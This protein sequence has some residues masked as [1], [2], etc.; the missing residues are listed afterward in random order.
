MTGPLIKLLI[1]PVDFDCN[2]ACGYCYNGTA[3]QSRTKPDYIISMGTIHKIFDGIVPL[4]KSDRLVV[5]WH[6]GE[7]TLPGQ[8]FYREAIRVQQQAIDSRYKVT[9]CMQTNGTLIDESWADLLAELKI[10][11]SVSIDG[12]RQLHDSIRKFFS[13]EESTY[14]L[15][16]RAYRLFQSRGINAGMLMVISQI[17]V[18]HPEAIWEWVL[19]ER[20]KHFDFLPCI[21]PELW[22][23]GKQVYGLST[24]DMA[25]F[26]IKFFDLWFDH[27]D[28]GIQIRTFR[29]A[30]KG[31][32]G[33]HVNIC[34]W[35]AGCLQ[36]ISFDARG[37]AYPCARYHCYPETRMGNIEE[38]SFSEIMMTPTTQWVH[39][40]I[41]SGQDKCKGC[42]WNP[43]CGSGCP[44]LKY[45]LHGHW[46]GPYVHCRS[47]QALF[48]HVR[49]RIFKK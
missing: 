20:I 43:I 33:G 48:A 29:D 14:D 40:G 44:F 37:N 26:S 27:G 41:K 39:Q 4:L 8:D 32:M 3:R 19:Q 28:P 7:P 34:S 18:N 9:N 15:G 24:A 21:E 5:I 42:E 10:G 16:M 25:Q 47:R 35:K 22:R 2:M 30:V 11:P 6:G 45:A 38:M 17:N 36:H 31:Q 1:T 49:E 12:P 23:E 46:D 13:N